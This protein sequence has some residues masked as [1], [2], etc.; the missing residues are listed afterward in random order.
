MDAQKKS[1][2][3][4]KFAVSKCVGRNYHVFMYVF[5]GL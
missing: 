5:G 3:M 4:M 2:T 1:S